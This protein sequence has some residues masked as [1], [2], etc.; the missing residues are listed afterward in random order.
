MRK[1]LSVT[2][3]IALLAAAG[4]AYA[5]TTDGTGTGSTDSAAPPAAAAKPFGKDMGKGMGK[6]MMNMG[7]SKGAVAGNNTELLALLGL[8]QA[9]LS[10]ELAAGKSLAAIAEAKG[11]AKDKV[12]E[13]LYNQE[14]ARLDQ[15][16]KDGK[17]TQTFVDQQKAALKD[18]IT[19]M[20]ENPGYG[21]HGKMG[22]GTD[23]GK[24]MAGHMGKG[25]GG[26]GFGN[27]TEAAGILGLTEQELKTELQS[28][29]SLSE[30]AQNKGISEDQLV[31]SLLEKAKERIKEYVGKKGQAPAAKTPAKTPAAT[32][33]AASS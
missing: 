19:A 14:A 25:R 9:S 8:D 16:V 10:Q 33:D 21:R 4:T 17:V 24:G 5:A 28:G 15:L 2:L 27:L 20:V 22:A 26:M 1:M 13:L 12:V 3:G 32:G 31:N 11:I 6:G 7:A 30:I 29:K 18:R 23:M